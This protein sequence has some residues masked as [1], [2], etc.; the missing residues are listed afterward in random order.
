MCSELNLFI[1]WEKAYYLKDKILNDI[2]NKFQILK[3]YEIEWD[4]EKYSENLSRFYGEKLPKN[5]HK[6]K[7]CGTGPFTL[8]IV[9]DTKPLYKTR[10]TSRGEEIVNINMFDAK[11]LYR[12]WTGGGHKIHSTNSLEETNHDIT[13]LF[14][15]N[16]DD[17]IKENK[18]PWNGIVERKKMNLIGSEGW[19]DINE[20]FYVLN[21]TCNYVVLRNF[22]DFPEAIE[23]EEHQDIDI[24]A[25]NYVNIS[26]ILNAKMKSKLK[27]RVINTVK[28]N[29]HEVDFDF[30][31]VGDNYY[32]E[33]WENS[34]LSNRVLNKD[35]F[36]SPNEKDYFYSLLYHGLVHKID[37]AEDYK[38]RLEGLAK[39]IGEK[40]FSIYNKPELILYNY[41][42]RNG[43]RIV[44][45]FDLS[46]YYN[47][48][49]IRDNSYSLK[50]LFNYNKLK[51]K[52]MLKKIIR[53]NK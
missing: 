52:A 20:V 30:R 6:E 27:Y 18:D 49:Y 7:H 50:R 47:K 22:E 14:G 21:S 36:Y 40:D 44:E 24:L 26:Y 12:E 51:I 19:K 45:P 8:V 48:K 2:N 15:K 23:L 29:G 41:L 34:I 43:Y 32:D 1:I 31:Y 42:Q 46:V 3:V 9:N 53:G 25:D 38:I 13:L 10:M 4:K 37:V 16:A 17:F 33:K 5:S 11:Q 28:I 35:L 39:N